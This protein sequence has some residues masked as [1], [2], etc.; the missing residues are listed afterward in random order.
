MINKKS[1]QSTFEIPI[2]VVTK[3]GTH[4]N[5]K[6]TKRFALPIIMTSIILGLISLGVWSIGGTVSYFY[7]NESSLANL[8]SAGAFDLSLIIQSYPGPLG[9]MDHYY[10]PVTFTEPQNTYYLHSASLSYPD[11]IDLKYIIEVDNMTGDDAVCNSLQVKATLSGEPGYEGLLRDLTIP[12]TDFS[13]TSSFITWIFK[14]IIPDDSSIVGE[15]QYDVVFKSWQGDFPV[16]PLGFN[17]V[18]GFHDTVIVHGLDIEESSIQIESA[19]EE[20]ESTPTL[21]ASS[22]PEPEVTL[23]PTPASESLTEE[24]SPSPE[25]T[26]EVA[27]EPTPEVNQD[28][29]LIEN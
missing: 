4:K 17:D 3:I 16:Y 21:E 14:F 28:S 24:V 15:C 1:N 18:E 25:P 5:Q 11:N 8:F 23:T 26:P 2:W 22:T 9:S 7:D 12:P 20:I 10:N 27:P 19:P 13:T 6:K 29:S